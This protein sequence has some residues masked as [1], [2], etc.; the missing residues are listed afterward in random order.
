MPVGGPG[1]VSL[2]QRSA[3]SAMPMNGICLSMRYGP[4]GP[5]G[6]NGDDG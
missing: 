5:Y 2:D 3:I 4:Y 6:S 1:V